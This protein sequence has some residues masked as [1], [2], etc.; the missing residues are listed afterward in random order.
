MLFQTDRLNIRELTADDTPFIFELLN[1]QGFKDNIADRGIDTLEKAL[2]EI[3]QRYAVDY[4]HFGLFV[5]ELKSTGE[6]LGGITLI[7][8]DT[9]DFPDLGYALLP[10]FY[11]KGYAY[12]ASIGLRDWAVSKN[13]PTLLAIVSP[14]NQASIRLLEKLDFRSAGFKKMNGPVETLLYFKF[15]ALDQNLTTKSSI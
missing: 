1:T 5:V 4:P 2:D 13:M 3:S 12:E 14:S 8:R 10:Q 15:S 9:L 6:A 7:E 11:A